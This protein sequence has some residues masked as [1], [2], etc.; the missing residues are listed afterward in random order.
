MSFFHE[1]EANRRLWSIRAANGFG[2]GA[3]LRVYEVHTYILLRDIPSRPLCV[4]QIPAVSSLFSIIFCP[5]GVPPAPSR[6]L[7]PVSVSTGSLPQG[8]RVETAAWKCPGRRAPAGGGGCGMRR[9]VNSFLS[10]SFVC[11]CMCKFFCCCCEVQALELAVRVVVPSLS[12]LEVL[13]V[14]TLYRMN[15]RLYLLEQQGT[16]TEEKQMPEVSHSSLLTK[17]RVLRASS[18]SKHTWCI[19]AR[20]RS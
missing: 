19:R 20:T 12:G 11:V 14:S 9:F 1:I 15:W 18:A 2:F 5:S 4:L 16:F 8:R 7:F 6:S 13:A 17:G 3:A 10:S